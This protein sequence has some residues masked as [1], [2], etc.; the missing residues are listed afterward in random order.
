MTV[1]FNS[2]QTGNGQ[3]KKLLTLVW[4]QECKWASTFLINT[5]A[6]LLV[7]A[8]LGRQLAC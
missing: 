1:D 7:L 8:V 6:G 3:R 2:T 5:S 4:F